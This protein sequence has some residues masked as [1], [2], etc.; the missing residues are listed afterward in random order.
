MGHSGALGVRGRT[1]GY[2][3]SRQPLERI[4]AHG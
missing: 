4:H 2:L 3:T 1:F